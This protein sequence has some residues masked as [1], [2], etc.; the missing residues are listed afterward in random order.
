MGPNDTHIRNLDRESAKRTD[1]SSAA[2]DYVGAPHFASF[3]GVFTGD[4][5]R[6]GFEFFRRCIFFAGGRMESGIAAGAWP[7]RY[8]WGTAKKMGNE[9]ARAGRISGSHQRPTNENFAPGRRVNRP[10]FTGNGRSL[11]LRDCGTLQVRAN[12]RRQ[13][14]DFSV[15]TQSTGRSGRARR[16]RCA[17]SNGRGL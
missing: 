6:N 14:K 11:S 12:R 7:L 10:C 9:R 15:D 2:V 3:H 4:R 13:R 16:K 1:Y 5:G 8:G 17:C